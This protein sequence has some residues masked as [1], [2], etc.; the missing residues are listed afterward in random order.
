MFFYSLKKDISNLSDA[1]LHCS[2][3]HVLRMSLFR[4]TLLHCALEN[5]N[6]LTTSNKYPP[7]MLFT[8]EANP[9][10]FTPLHRLHF[11]LNYPEV[12][13]AEANTVHAPLRH[14]PS[15]AVTQIPGVHVHRGCVDVHVTT[16]PMA[17][18]RLFCSHSD[19]LISLRGTRGAQYYGMQF[20]QK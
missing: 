15:A 2:C 9:L 18:S 4:M 13:T 6:T 17:L 1:L 14:A 11:S 3:C 5:Q 8:W 10:T 20:E 19:W 12:H 7:W 16:H